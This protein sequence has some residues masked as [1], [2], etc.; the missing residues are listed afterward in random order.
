[1]KRYYSALIVIGIAFIIFNMFVHIMHWPSFLWLQSGYLIIAIIYP[2]QILTKQKNLVNIILS[3]ALII[4]AISSILFFNTDGLDKQIYHPFINGALTLAFFARFYKFL[5][6]DIVQ[7]RPFQILTI[8]PYIHGAIFFITAI[9]FRAL[10]WPDVDL[11]LSIGI[12][13]MGIAL[14]FSIINFDKKHK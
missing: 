14:F 7:D 10:H 8:I 9:I 6:L 12:V 13:T 1:M 3:L 2:I 11:L 5:G 4:W